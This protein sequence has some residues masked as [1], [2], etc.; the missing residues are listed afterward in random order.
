MRLLLVENSKTVTSLLMT[1]LAKVIDIHIDWAPSL[2]DV[3]ELIEKNG[4]QNYTLA[5]SCLN[6]ADAEDGEAVSVITEFQIPTIVFSGTFEDSLRDQFLQMPG[7]IDYVVK[8]SQASLT[9][10]CNMVYRLITNRTIK[11]LVVDG[12]RP[13]R[14]QACELLRQYQFQVLEA[15]NGEEALKILQ[16]NRDIKLVVTDYQMAPV[17]GFELTKKIRETYGKDELAIIGLSV[18]EAVSLSARFIKVGAND[19]LPRPFQP[20]E[21]HCRV[22]QNIE[23]IE[24]TQKLVDAATKDFLTGLYNRRF[25]F[26][27]GEKKFSR[28]KN[29]RK[30][31]AICMLD[32]D[33]FK[34][35]N[36]TFGHDVGDEVLKGVSLQL[37]SAVRK[38]DMVARLG[39]EEF[40]I[41]LDDFAEG[42]LF[43]MLDALRESIEFKQ[44][45]CLEDRGNV[46]SSFGVAKFHPGDSLDDLLKRADELLY[47]AKQSGRNQVIIE[48]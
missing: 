29:Q 41:F 8:E 5:I 10:L 25:F 11:T 12:S 15:E 35:V 20:E 19:F 7:V 48:D 28:L 22:A 26:D 39:G 32:I 44:Y 45:D 17:D 16:E 27:K 30:P 13:M 34:S 6:L 33:H 31:I 36:D 4:P 2:S 1:E 23:L 18:V 40:C 37:L 42:E 3:F 24:K 46:T 14:L 47:L 9:Y 43:D 21:F 38:Q